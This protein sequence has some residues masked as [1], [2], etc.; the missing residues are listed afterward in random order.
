MV[1]A[2]TYGKQPFFHAPERRDLLLDGLLAITA[3]H[4]WRLRAWAVLANHYHFVAH[5]SGKPSGLSRL[6]GKLHMLT[7][8]AVNGMDGAPGRK[9]WFQFWDSHITYERSYLA[10]LRYV[11]TNPVHHG[12]VARAEDYPWCSAAWF[13]QSA[14]PAFVKTVGSFRTDSVNVHDDY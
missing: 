14:S 1:T 13:A 6:L 7:A 12:L 9:V 11:H 4:G 8:K 2:G 3:E 10:R 5:F